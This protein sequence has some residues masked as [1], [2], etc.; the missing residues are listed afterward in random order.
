MYY[1][2]Y[3]ITNNSIRES[4]INILKDESFVRIQKSV[5]C[6]S[7]SGQQKKNLIEKVNHVISHDVDSFYLIMSC[8]QCF[9]KIITIGKNFDAEYV[10]NQ[11]PSIVL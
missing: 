11:K 7:L 10:S 3:D 6:G 1:A 5:F 4:L 8:S 9:G 2:V